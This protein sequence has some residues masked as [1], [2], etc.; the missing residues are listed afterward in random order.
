MQGIRAPAQAASTRLEGARSP[1][2]R[3]SA[4]VGQVDD[5]ESLFAGDDPSASTPQ[6][7]VRGVDSH[8]IRSHPSKGTERSFACR[9]ETDPHRTV[10]PFPS[11]RQSG[12]RQEVL[13]LG[14]LRW[15]QQTHWCALLRFRPCWEGP[16]VGQ[17][18]GRAAPAQ[19]PGSPRDKEG[20]APV[21]P[22][23]RVGCPWA[24]L[25]CIIPGQ[26]GGGTRAAPEPANHHRPTD[27]ISK[28]CPAP[29]WQM[30]GREGRG[31]QGPA[32]LEAGTLLGKGEQRPRCLAMPE[33]PPRPAS[34]PS[35]AWPPST[36]PS[37][38]T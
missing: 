18:G 17:A 23:A 37:L 12:R 10:L 38:A 7:Q 13:T 8:G 29:G 3:P 9:G 15:P 35:S 33:P 11:R 16:A 26:E 22:M 4:H 24:D 25:S 27:P 32:L 6:Y 2:T 19:R 1:L 20:A 36:C 5:S 21:T 34:P 31:A 30:G 28:Q 14:C